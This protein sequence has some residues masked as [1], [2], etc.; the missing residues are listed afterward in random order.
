M[1][2]ED[3]NYELRLC[4][5][6]DLRTVYETLFE[7]RTNWYNIG[8]QLG[9]PEAD[10]AAIKLE[11]SM[12][13]DCLR[14]ALA[15]WLRGVNQDSKPTWKR[16]V[17]ALRSQSVSENQLA[18]FIEEK[19]CNVGEHQVA[20][21]NYSDYLRHLYR[22]FAP[23]RMLQWPK[24]PHYEFVSLAMIKREK[25]VRGKTDKFVEL[26]LHG[27]VDDITQQK[28]KIDLKSIFDKIETEHEV[29]LL[30]G[31]PGAGK[32]MLIWHI[33]HEWGRN[34]L[35]TQ[36]SIIVLATLRDPE[37]QKAKSITDVLALTCENRRDAEKVA[38]RMRAWHGRNILFLLDGWDELPE[39]QRKSKAFLFSELIQRPEKHCLEKAAIIVTSRPVSSGDLRQSASMRIEIVGFI[40][41]NIKEYFKTCLKSEEGQAEALDKLLQILEDNPL[42]ESIC[43]LPLNAAIV[44]YLFCA[45]DHTLPETYHELFQL[46]V[47]HC[48]LRHIE[49]S[50]L[51]ITL[52][53][54]QRPSFDKF[55][56]EISG[57][58]E[59]VC[60]L[61][62]LASRKNMIT[63]SSATLCEE[64]GVPESLN[65]LGL[66]QTVKSL[67]VH[68][69]GTTYHFLHLSL[70]ELLAAYHI[71]KMTP[72]SQLEVFSEMLN[73]PRFTAVFGF[74][75]GFTKL[76]NKEIQDVVAEIVQTERKKS[77]DKTLLVSLM[78]WLY[79]ARDL[80][81]CH[82][83]QGELTRDQSEK[84][85]EGNG[86]LDLSHTSLK[87]SD[88][89]SVGYFMSTVKTESG[90]PFCVDLSNCRLQ[91]HHAKFLV[92]GLSQGHPSTTPCIG[93]DLSSNSMDTMGINHVADFLKESQ[94]I[95]A[96]NLMKNKLTHSRLFE[97]LVKNSSLI[98]L[99][100]SQ[101]SLTVEA[102][103]SV[104]ALLANNHCLQSLD[105]SSST[106][107]PEC[108]ADGL[109]QNSTL[110]ILNMKYC[111][112]TAEGMRQISEAIKICHLEE[113]S[114]G[115]LLDDCMGP[116]TIALTT[117][118][119][120][121][122]RG[123][124][125]TNQGLHIIGEALQESTSLLKLYLQDFHCVTSEGLSK[126]G[127]Q[128]EGN[129]TLEELTMINFRDSSITNGLRNF[130]T[131]FQ[132]NRTLKI[133][134]LSEN[135]VENIREIIN[136]S[137]QPPLKLEAHT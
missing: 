49:R 111:N 109:K 68:G 107:S 89:L 66:M 34:K 114:V 120:L 25:L 106:I 59:Q 57:P 45:C 73:Q 100:I 44:V 112:V 137:R 5:N 1:L 42:I 26:T 101:C 90:K 11:N 81:L 48:I 3:T 7:A 110:K 123:E 9:L 21:V 122:L 62:Y 65:H 132:K 104:T 93:I 27:C 74:Y 18:Q 86:V 16:L 99:D 41:S 6:L 4:S 58:F 135:E 121:S 32:T 52:S 96:L 10:L 54:H 97:A 29:I 92:K 33:C 98:K 43:Y 17:D 24:L 30:E 15:K 51:D 31:A 87:P 131:C 37:V 76:R 124:Q 19:Y 8:L 102:G 105:I 23:V 14:E 35:F 113:L 61:A 72:D 133:L 118:Q 108:I 71:S 91:D 2:L 60:K 127:E 36:F 67:L 12:L 40:A 82:F 116:L 78:N 103:E 46:L 83:V 64:F 84:L 117:L 79:E 95:Q 55:P 134:K 129:Q 77:A 13:Q 75:A 80:E 63:F 50:N 28:E 125:I 56:E 115:P 130:V 70:Q 69:E 126:L 88:A 22:D 20:R 128:L 53:Q 39:E 136:K 85:N 119:S 47:Y 94:L 38:A